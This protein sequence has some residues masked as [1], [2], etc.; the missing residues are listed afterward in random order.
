MTRIVLIRHGAVDLNGVAYGRRVDPGLS[1]TG[2]AE[3][4]ALRGRLTSHGPDRTRLGDQAPA[5]VVH[6]PARRAA[7]SADLLG[8][9]TDHVDPRWIERDL[10]TWE[11]RPWSEL[12][13]EAPAEVQTDPA[14]FAAFT[15]PDGETVPQLQDRVSDALEELARDH[16]QTDPTAAPPVM[17]VCH[18]GP[19]VC[20]ISHVL[21]LDP[22][23]ALRI[24]VATAT[25]T[26]V[27]RWPQGAWTLEGIAT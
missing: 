15:P 4:A 5:Y 16:A 23:A 9:T 27:T 19:I 8:W 11:G 17:V 10:G 2:V 24:R 12:W 3:V 7:R 13:N 14:S 18:G 25:A 21:G 26:W 6:S 1:D 22:V 20:A